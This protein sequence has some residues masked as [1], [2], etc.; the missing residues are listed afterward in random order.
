MRNMTL[1]ATHIAKPAKAYTPDWSG[2]AILSLLTG[3]L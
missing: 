1:T 3:D 2:F